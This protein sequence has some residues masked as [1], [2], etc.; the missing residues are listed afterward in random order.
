MK[1]GLVIT[2]LSLLLALASLDRCKL[3]RPGLLLSL[4]IGLLIASPYLVW[5]LDSLD[6]AGASLGKLETDTGGLAARAAGIWALAR[7]LVSFAAPLLLVYW[8]VF[9][10]WPDWR[11]IA[12]DPARRGPAS[13]GRVRMAAP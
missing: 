7:A 9:R 4:F 10:A 5:L 13:G 12:R 6:A 11:R 2:V 1:R 3:L 8:L